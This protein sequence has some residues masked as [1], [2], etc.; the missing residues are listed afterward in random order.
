MLQEAKSKK[1]REVKTVREKEIQEVQI[2]LNDIEKEQKMK[3]DKRIREK[4][5]AMKIIKMNEEEKV[6]RMEHKEK[7]RLA[8]IKLIDDYNEMLDKQEKQRAQEWANREQ[9][10][11]NS[12]AKMGDVIKK[13]ND[14]EQVFEQK[15]LRDIMKKDKEGEQREQQKRE[16]ARKRHR[17]LIFELG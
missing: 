9:R 14:A 4:I 3:V 11:K 12:M 1:I 6:K 13:N 7:E 10:I 8:Q 5:E 17:D 2:L 16:A 15:L